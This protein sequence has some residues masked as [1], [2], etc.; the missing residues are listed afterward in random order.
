MLSLFRWHFISCCPYSAFGLF[1][2]YDNPSTFYF[3]L[4]KFRRRLTYIQQ[5]A[6]LMAVHPYSSC[7]QAHISEKP[8]SWTLNGKQSFGNLQTNLQYSVPHCIRQLPL[9]FLLRK[10]LVQSHLPWITSTN[11]SV[12]IFG[13]HPYIWAKQNFSALLLL[14]VGRRWEAT[15]KKG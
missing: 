7:R 5:T 8:T 10:C 4:S 9:A 6:D 11:A 2:G 12:L 15:E 3:I 13:T 1:A 14:L